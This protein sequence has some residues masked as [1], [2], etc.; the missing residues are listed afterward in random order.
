M[1]LELDEA[2]LA[3]DL[4]YVLGPTDP[5]TV[6][7]VAGARRILAANRARTYLD[8]LEVALAHGA[9]SAAGDGKAA[10]VRVSRGA[11]VPAS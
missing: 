8:H 1:R 6:E 10:S 3:I 5:L 9:Y 7:A 11:S 4:A 2:I